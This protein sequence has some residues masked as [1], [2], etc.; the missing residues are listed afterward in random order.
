MLLSGAILG[1]VLVKA[2]VDALVS[3]GRL[4]GWPVAQAESAQSEAR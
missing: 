4:R 2:V 3:A 1:G